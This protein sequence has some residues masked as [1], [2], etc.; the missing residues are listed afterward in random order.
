MQKATGMYVSNGEFTAAALLSHISVDTQNYNP[1][2]WQ[3]PPRP[4]VWHEP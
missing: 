2:C 1:F 3:Q 4:P